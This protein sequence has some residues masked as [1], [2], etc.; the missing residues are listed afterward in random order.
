MRGLE[1]AVVVAV[2]RRLSKNRVGERLERR[3]ASGD[4][5]VAVGD[6]R[7]PDERLDAAARLAQRTRRRVDRERGLVAEQVAGQRAQH[8]RRATGARPAPEIVSSAADANRV[9]SSSAITIGAALCAR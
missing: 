9:S 4:E 7:L 6:R 3:P 5:R 1:A 8:E 2:L